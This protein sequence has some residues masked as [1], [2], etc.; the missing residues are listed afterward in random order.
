MIPIDELCVKLSSLKDKLQL[1]CSEATAQQL[2]D[3]QTQLLNDSQLLSR[4]VTKLSSSLNDCLSLWEQYGN[5][6]D[7]MSHRIS[8]L[9][10]KL[11]HDFKL[12][13]NLDEKL[14]QLNKAK[15]RSPVFCSKDI[16]SGA[17]TC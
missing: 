3:K 16:V 12:P 2:N 4:N 10:E 13:S 1:S 17:Q 7:S 6:T 15:V 5:Q 8:A 9:E 14:S 11:K